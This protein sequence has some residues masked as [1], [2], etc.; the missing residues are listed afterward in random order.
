[1]PQEIGILEISSDDT[2]YKIQHPKVNRKDLLKNWLE[3]DVSMISGD[4]QGL[5]ERDLVLSCR[6]S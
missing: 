6:R 1:M 5:F 4:L 3:N 2:I